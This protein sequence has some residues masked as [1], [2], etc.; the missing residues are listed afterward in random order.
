MFASNFT[1]Q[2]T[3]LKHIRG[4]EHLKQ[5]SQSKTIASGNNM[6]NY[7]CDTC[8][9]LLYRISSGFSDKSILRIGTVDDFT[10]HEGK[11]RPQIEQFVG[12]RPDWLPGVE[13]TRKYEGESHGGEKPIGG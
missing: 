12:R 13:G 6:T 7:F 5:Y 2:N 9:S 4:K 1:V 11:L 3:H 10:L 8:G